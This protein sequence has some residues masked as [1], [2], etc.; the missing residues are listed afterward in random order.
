V[1]VNG[2]YSGHGV[3][4]SASGARRLAELIVDPTANERNPFSCDR[5]LD[6]DLED[7]VESLVI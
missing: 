4:G 2:G 5:S 3:M 6:S 1:Y 7:D